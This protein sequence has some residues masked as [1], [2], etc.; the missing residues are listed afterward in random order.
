MLC[1]QVDGNNNDEV[2]L[3]ARKQYFI[4]YN[5]KKMIDKKPTSSSSC[6]NLNKN[7]TISS[8]PSSTSS[9]TAQPKTSTKNKRK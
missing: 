5:L 1:R 6:D 3:P 9:T 4:C 2:L 7:T 8:K